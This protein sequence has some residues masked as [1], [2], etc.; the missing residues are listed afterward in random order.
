MEYSDMS[1]I[2]SP[3]FDPELDPEI[4]N[5]EIESFSDEI[6]NDYNFR[7]YGKYEELD[8]YM[9]KIIE[10]QEQLSFIN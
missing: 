5:D 2:N 8:F 6:L 10:I 1:S 3:W 9:E 4:G 7:A